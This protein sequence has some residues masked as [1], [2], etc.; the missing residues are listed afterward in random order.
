MLWRWT[1]V[2]RSNREFAK[3]WTGQASSS[4][5]SAVTTVAMPLTAVVVLHA[6][7]LQMGVLSALTV[8][9]HLLFGL[10]AG[11]W[12]DRFR[13]RPILIVADLGR[14]LLLGTI[15]VLGAFGLL[16]I[17]HLCAVAFLA[18]A[19]TLFSD[20][21][22]TTLVP[23]LVDRKRLMEANGASM[24]NQTVAATAGPSVA[25]GLVQL[26]TAPIAI[27]LDAISY[28]VSAVC[29]FLI[30]E[31]S[32]PVRSD[33]SRPRSAP[34]RAQL[35]E[36]L[37]AVFGN[38]LMSALAVSATLGAVAGAMQGPLVVLYMVRELRL[39]PF[40][41]GVAVTVVGVASVAG[42]L[43]AP[44]FSDRLGPGRSYI[45]GQLLV[46][47]AGFVLA[48]PGGPMV[49][50]ASVLFLGQTLTGLG[51]P[52]FAVPQ[53]T[54]RQALVPDHLLGRVTATWRT[55]VI[56][57]QTF[58][59]LLGGL[60]GT[61]LRLRPT[62][63]LSGAGMLLGFLWAARSPLRSLTHVPGAEPAT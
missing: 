36:G 24:L 4:F 9:P 58:G 34:M 6:S 15:P 26:V 23:A 47:L 29:S 12:V 11:V 45:V 55:L 63:I 53:R 42:A 28:L 52:L 13:R 40:L 54:L 7:P 56:G 50:L 30:R 19:L 48:A 33:D 14:A 10:P 5:G 57:G 49:L 31:P 2:L 44:A 3:L 35:T 21:A 51:L 8:V 46:S 39:S 43:V 20:T 22:S 16:R 18:G 41:V 32:H 38:P 59:A 37:R 17:E 60:L 25:G 62:L 1:E 61:A 27:A